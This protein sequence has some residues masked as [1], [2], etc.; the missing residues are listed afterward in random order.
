MNCTGGRGF[1]R[2]GHSKIGDEL[3]PGL[4][5][6]VLALMAKLAD[7]SLK[8]GFT[9]AFEVFKARPVVLQHILPDDLLLLFLLRRMRLPRRVEVIICSV[10][11]VRLAGVIGRVLF[12]CGYDV[13]DVPVVCG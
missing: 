10:R 5:R 4:G 3:W 7:V 1:L 13:V 12:V 9:Q 6:A 2:R 11:V 8:V